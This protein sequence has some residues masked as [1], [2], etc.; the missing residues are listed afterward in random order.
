MWG[1]RTIAAVDTCPAALLDSI[2]RARTRVV[3][4]GVKH[5]FMTAQRSTAT[6]GLGF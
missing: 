5:D 2:L 6:D 3:S 4:H 1:P